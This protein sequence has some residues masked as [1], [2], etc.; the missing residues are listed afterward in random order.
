MVSTGFLDLPLRPAKP[1]NAGLSH[2][3]DKGL[4]LA[5]TEGLLRTA[6]AYVDVWK[7]GW[8]TAYLDPDL[9]P[10]LAQLASHDVKSCLG[11]TLLEVAWL[12]GKAK[13]CLSWAADVG[14][15]MVEVSRGVAPMNLADKT[16]LIEFAAGTF[17]VLSEVGSKDPGFRADPASWSHEVTGDLAAGAWKVVAEGRESGTVGLYDG[18]GNVRADVADAIA[19]TAGATNILFETPQKDQQAWFI[20]TFGPD[21]NL[22]NIAH[23]DLVGVEALRLGLRADT[24]TVP[25]PAPR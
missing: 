22:A 25:P 8:G 1:R 18:N 14:F 16:E 20:R 9:G 17:T 2:M 6:G 15:G 10:K 3:L 19:S 11:G 23:D 13:A 5:A 24:V 12:Q 7:F 4:S 21:V